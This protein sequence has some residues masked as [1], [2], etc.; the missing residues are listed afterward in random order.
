MLSES[1]EAGPAAGFEQFLHS[2]GLA[3]GLPAHAYTSDGF[4]RLESQRLFARGWMFVGFAH[5]LAKAGD[6]MPVVAAGRPVLLMRSR[7]GAVNAFANVCR[8]RC[9]RLVEAPGNVGP[10]L[11]CPYHSW[12]YG[13]DGELRSAPFFGGPDNTPPAGLDRSRLGLKPVRCRVW[14]DWIFINLDGEAEDLDDFVAPLARRLE[15]LDLGALT[16]VAV[17]EFP[18]IQTNWKF[19]MENFIEPYHVPVVH[20]GTT[21]QPLGDHYTVID[22]HC[23]GSAVEVSEGAA[24]GSRAG[25]LA[26]SSRY[27]TLFPNFVLGRYHP[28]QL[29]VHLNL[30]VAP[31]MTCQRRAIYMTGGAQPDPER[32]EALKT[33]W[34]AVHREDHEVCERL[35]RGRDSEVAEDGGVL[36]P[37]WEDSLRRFQ[38]LVVNAVA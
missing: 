24:A 5:E 19:L 31:G 12:V 4:F 13:L 29:G 25:T 38:E 34:S 20:S 11:R 10:V 8:H 26:V 15:D 6:V 18:R 17:I 1:V 14:H 23:L 32:V 9:A 33:L 35:Q 2:D 37:Y 3:H 16:P 7:S 30:P 21:D 36:S 28:D 27:L 22:G